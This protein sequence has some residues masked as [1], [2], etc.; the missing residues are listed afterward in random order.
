MSAIYDEPRVQYTPSAPEP[1]SSPPP[2]RAPM[3]RRSSNRGQVV[4]AAVAAVLLIGAAAES[5]PPGTPGHQLWTSITSSGLAPAPAVAAAQP[6]VDPQLAAIQQVIQ[7]ANTEQTQAITTQ[8]PSVMSDTATPAHYQQLVQINQNLVAQGVTGIQLTNLAWGP[9]TI[10]GTT[11]T[12]TSYET[13]V[14]TF[15]DST[16]M[17]STDTNVYTLVQQAGSWIVQDDQQPSATPTPGTPAQP[18]APGS[19]AQP[20][21][22]APAAQPAP[23][24]AAPITQGTS[25]NW[26]GY[27][28]TNSNHSATGV[29]GTW[30]VPQLAPNGVPGVGATWVGIGG[31]TGRDLIQAGTQDV[32]SG[33]GQ[34]QFQAWIEMLPQASRQVP[35]AVAPGDSVTVSINETGPATGVWQVAFKNNTSGQTYQTTVNYTSSQSSAEW[36]E[37]APSGPNG[38][39][40]LDNFGSIAFS[41]ATATVNGQTVDLSQ[42]GAQPITM[43]NANN[44]S[45][46]VPSTIGS[47]GASFS[48]ARTSAS[49]TPAPASNGRRPAVPAN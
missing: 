36:I 1:V 10:N 13:W 23:L 17:Q 24:P 41:G 49:A 39:V 45:L 47:D 40:P 31:V 37:E 38:V 42:A 28:A 16:T 3:R 20:A 33:T 29:T 18:A 19:P 22:P 32:A 8:N 11:A 6:Q 2:P 43:L 48:V 26:S 12:A 30:T 27:A 4:A 14:T 15:S 5:V 35:L 25:H 44:Q 46:A 9:I 34:S 7:R 21:A